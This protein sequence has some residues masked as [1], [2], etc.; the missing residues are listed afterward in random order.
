MKLF[1]LLVNDSHEDQEFHEGL[2]LSQQQLHLLHHQ[3]TEQ[4]E[5][6]RNTTAIIIGTVSALVFIISVILLV[7]W[8][9]RYWCNPFGVT[10]RPERMPTGMDRVVMSELPDPEQ[11]HYHPNFDFAQRHGA[12]F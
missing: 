7:C 9:G 10:R 1:Q 12:V 3:L 4:F 6:S 8:C 2:R 5:A 11:N